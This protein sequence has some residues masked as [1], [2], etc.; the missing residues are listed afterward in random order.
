VGIESFSNRVLKEMGEHSDVAR[1]NEGLPMLKRHG[2]KAFM[3]IILITP[4][5]TLDDLELTVD[6]ALVYAND[7]AYH[8]GITLAI[9]PLKGTD[10]FET[11][12]N[13]LS[14]IEKIPSANAH[15]KRDDMIL[16]DG[17]K[18]R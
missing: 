13:Y 15:I 9:K 11:K 12:T 1:N 16:V 18:A 2:L 6:S 4:E 8:A 5:T 3:N 17:Q 7:D 10:F 14:E